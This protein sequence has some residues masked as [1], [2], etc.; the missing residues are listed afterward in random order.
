MTTLSA[1][2]ACVQG[3]DALRKKP[4]KVRSLQ[5]HYRVNRRE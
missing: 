3:I 2:A 4:L 1:A 5:E